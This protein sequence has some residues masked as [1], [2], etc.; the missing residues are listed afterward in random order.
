MATCHVLENASVREQRAWRFVRQ[1]WIAGI[2]VVGRF[3]EFYTLRPIAGAMLLAK[4]IAFN[5]LFEKFWEA[6]T[7]EKIMPENG[8]RPP[9]AKA[10]RTRKSIEKSATLSL[11]LFLRV[12]F[13]IDLPSTLSRAAATAWGKSRYT[14]V[15]FGDSPLRSSC[16][17]RRPASEKNCE[18]ENELKKFS[19]SVAMGGRH[20]VQIQ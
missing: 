7:S 15:H 11:A 6:G 5:S 3:V 4:T 2:G 1:A 10:H 19:S 8:T 13:Y 20:C 16:K 14:S 18:A 17:S 12:Y 9:F